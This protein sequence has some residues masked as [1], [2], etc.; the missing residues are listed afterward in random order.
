MHHIENWK[1]I[2][3]HEGAY[4]VS[5]FG[6]VRSLPRTVEVKLAGGRTT[7]RRVPGKHLAPGLDSSGYLSVQLGRRGGSIR[8]HWLVLSAFEGAAPAEAQR[9]HKDGNR[10]NNRHANLKY[11][12]RSENMQDLFRHGQRAL[13]A[14]QVELVRE[15]KLRASPV[16][17]KKSWRPVSASASQR[18]TM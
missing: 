2:P 4:E 16:T 1:P 18:S 12:T 11:G 17:R 7:H 8:V 5:D 14:E 13:N 6:R 3:G 9:L 15:R 10:I